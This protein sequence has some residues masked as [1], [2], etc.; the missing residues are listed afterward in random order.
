V[1]EVGLAQVCAAQDGMLARSVADLDPRL[2][3][4]QQCLERIERG[5][6]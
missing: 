1:D 3:P 5:R 4:G 6:G 2:V